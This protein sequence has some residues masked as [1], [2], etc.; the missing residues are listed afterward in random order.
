MHQI[1]F[2][3]GTQQVDT[4]IANCDQMLRDSG[5]VIVRNL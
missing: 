3:L 2:W 4:C 1:R 5:I